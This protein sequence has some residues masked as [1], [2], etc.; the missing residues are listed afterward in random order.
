MNEIIF[1]KAAAGSVHRNAE[2]GYV[3][4]S[5]NPQIEQ[6]VCGVRLTRQESAAK[7]NRGAHIRKEPSKLVGE[8]SARGFVPTDAIIGPSSYVC[9]Q[10]RSN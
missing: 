5:P 8:G 7:N 4:A 10:A 9:V 2:I 3:H 6:N 1:V